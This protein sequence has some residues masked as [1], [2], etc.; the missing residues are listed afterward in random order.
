[1]RAATLDDLNP[2][3][4]STYLNPHLEVLEGDIGPYKGC[5]EPYWEYSGLGCRYTWRSRLLEAGL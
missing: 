3:S 1:M 5:I 2:A 4:P